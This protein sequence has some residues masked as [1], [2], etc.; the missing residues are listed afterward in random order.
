M[1][2]GY[3]MGCMCA[4]LEAEAACQCAT[5]PLSL[6]AL[7]LCGLMLLQEDASQ[8]HSFSECA[9][10]PLGQEG[11]SLLQSLEALAASQRADEHR[12]LLMWVIQQLQ[13]IQKQQMGTP[14]DGEGWRR[15]EGRGGGGRE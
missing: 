12:P 6:Q 11:R 7:Y 10:E 8:S 15:G 2:C 14:V 4:T 13:V 1:V 5:H 9:T 3:H